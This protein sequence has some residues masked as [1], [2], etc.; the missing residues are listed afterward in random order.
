MNEQKQEYNYGYE[1]EKKNGLDFLKF[2]LVL[3]AFVLTLLFLRVFFIIPFSMMVI[4]P[5]SGQSL[6]VVFAVEHLYKD[7]FCVAASIYFSCLMAPKFRM[8]IS[9]FYMLIFI[10]MIPRQLEFALTEGA[11]Y[12]NHAWKT[13]YL[14]TLYILSGLIP[15]LFF[16]KE[17]IFSDK[18]RLP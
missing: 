5:L 9:I 18:S 12:G 13:P 2:I 6:Q 3:P 7:F 14:I 8:Q 1:P 17:R 4:L 15:F 16:L 11:S 10:L